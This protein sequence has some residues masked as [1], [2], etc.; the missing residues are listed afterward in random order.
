MIIAYKQAHTPPNRGS[1]HSTRLKDRL[2]KEIPGLRS[3][4]SGRQI[5]LIFQGDIGEAICQAFQSGTD[6]DAINK[7]VNKKQFQVVCIA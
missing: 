6:D 7:T 5:Y 2:L 1:V 3:E 4:C